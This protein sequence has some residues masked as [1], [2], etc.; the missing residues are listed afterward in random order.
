MTSADPPA[1]GRELA[2]ASEAEQRAAFVELVLANP[3][4]AEIVE[5]M[6]ATS[7]PQ[8]YLTAG[9]LFQTVWNL[10]DGRDPQA[11][12]RDYD[13]FYFDASD[14]SYDAEDRAIG[15]VRATLDGLDIPV[16]VRNEA[17]VHLWYARKF[18]TPCPPL[19]ST[20]DAIDHFPA[21]TCCLGLRRDQVGTLRVYAPHGFDDLFRG[22][23]QPNPV[24]A[25][26]EVYDAKAARW[27]KQWPWLHVL[28][29]PAGRDLPPPTR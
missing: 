25:P 20:E 16:E 5:R 26:R 21:T 8:W 3:S 28:P 29:W 27:Q 2:T 6:P 12:I 24:L 22:V 14:L 10:L 7:L 18:G 15:Q 23:I 19:R 11:G 17:R 13:L 1:R 4:V 9:A